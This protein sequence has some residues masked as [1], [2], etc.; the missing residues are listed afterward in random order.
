M[1]NPVTILHADFMTCLHLNTEE[2]YDEKLSV[3]GIA[4]LPYMP[5]IT[6]EILTY[7]FRFVDTLGYQIKFSNCAVLLVF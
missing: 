7:F 4:S 1:H 5:C 6:S 2:H 3:K